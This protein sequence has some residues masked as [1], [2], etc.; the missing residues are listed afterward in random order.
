MVENPCS[1]SVIVG[2]GP[3]GLA[4]AIM[5]S[6]QGF[7]KIKVFEQLPE[8][9]LASD[10]DAWG[11]FS[12]ERSYILG[13]SGKGQ[14][15]L[16]EIGAAETVFQYTQ[17]VNVRFDLNINR[18]LQLTRSAD[19]DYVTK[20]IERDRLTA[21]LLEVIR[22]QHRNNIDVYFNAK[23]RSLTW[24]NLNG[25]R[26]QCILDFYRHLP[27][28]DLAWLHEMESIK[29][30]SPF[31]IGAD[32]AGSV[33]RNAFLENNPKFKL[34]RFVDT[35]V[36]Y[37]KTIKLT[38]SNFS[39]NSNSTNYSLNSPLGDILFDALPVRE[40][41]H[42]GVILYRPGNADMESIRSQR[43]AQHFFK[44]HFP[45]LV[46][47]INDED[48]ELFANKNH[49]KFQQFQYASPTLHTG[50]SAVL[51]GDA[52]H[53]VKPY[54]GFGVNSALEDVIV[55]EKAINSSETL[56]IA[57]KA[58]SAA[59]AK[60]AKTLVEMTQELD[61]NILSL[62]IPMIVDTIFHSLNP[63]IFSANTIAALQDRRNSYSDVYRRK[64]FE[65]MLQVGIL[66]TIFMGIGVFGLSAAR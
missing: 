43:D 52:I 63:S 29:L 22:N 21:A 59:R 58:F 13:L 39:A 66:L 55:L 5:L 28:S 65:R 16:R 25:N 57:L 54:F 20:C 34:Q 38:F 17:D 60:E 30:C 45:V 49:S 3:S 62:A 27:Q 46:P 6:N 15:A 50:S 48:F 36:R 51:L 31:V 1:G 37:Y 47:Y 24:E 32:G 4:A 9:P 44:K 42:L 18:P 41:V 35:N 10:E 56:N 14:D 7:R 26:E 40:G 2:G 23:C 8:P 61:R 12:K 11:K 19:R 33:V 64:G 53:T